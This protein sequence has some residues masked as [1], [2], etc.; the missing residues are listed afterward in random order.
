MEE[1]KKYYAESRGIP[2][3]PIKEEVKKEAKFKY[4]K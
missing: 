3:K 4:S 2:L 1:Y